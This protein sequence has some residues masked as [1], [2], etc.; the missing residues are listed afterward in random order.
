MLAYWWR[1][2]ARAAER[3][4]L[5]SQFSGVGNNFGDEL[6]RP[7]LEQFI[8]DELEWAR[9]RDAEIVAIGSI[10]THLPTDWGGTIL[11][12]GVLNSKRKLDL[13]QAR[14]LALR[15]ALTARRVRT[16]G[17]FALGDP[18]L[19][20][21][22]LVEPVE[23]KYEVGLLPHW[24]DRS[25]EAKFYKPTVRVIRPIAIDPL[26]V[27]REIAACE[28]LICSSLHGVIVADAFGIPCRPERFGRM[29]HEGGDFKFRDYASALGVRATFGRM[30][31]VPRARVEQRQAELL[32]A[33]R[34][35]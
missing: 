21:P 31:E 10:L 1:L 24:S 16:N 9:P 14:V 17:D 18:G 22:L 26:Q 3:V 2:T 5:S 32:D 23:T 12:S 8:G 11:G 19:L 27:V 29:R 13:T 4:G 33:F 34:A 25:L 30:R 35:A 20:A 15:G 6:A 28:S 7:V